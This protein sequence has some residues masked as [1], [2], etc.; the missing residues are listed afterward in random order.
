MDGYLTQQWETAILRML[1]ASGA[2]L[3]NCSVV[4]KFE[5]YT[6]AWSSSSFEPYS[7]MNLMLKTEKHEDMM[8][9]Q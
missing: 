9:K 8:G 5:G 1:K 4:G 6:E 3:A 2:D 7:I